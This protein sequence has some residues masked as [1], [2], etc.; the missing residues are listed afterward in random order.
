MLGMD[1]FNPYDYSIDYNPEES[2]CFIQPQYVEADAEVIY[3]LGDRIM[4]KG[5]AKYYP[6][7]FGKYL[8]AMDEQSWLD[9]QK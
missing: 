4:T 5:C 3:R 8:N 9:P 1:A 7:S 2:K 6:Y